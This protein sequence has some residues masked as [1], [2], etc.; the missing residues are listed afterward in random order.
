M[1]RSSPG[2][3]ATHEFGKN[4]Y[5]VK[6]FGKTGKQININRI[7]GDVYEVPKHDGTIRVDYTLYANY[8]DG[9]YAG[10]DAGGIHLNMPAVFMWIKGYDKIPIDIRF[11]IPEGKQWTIAT[12]LK[13]AGDATSFTAPGL[14]Y[15][16][17]CPTKI[18]D[19]VWK[20]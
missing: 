17:D 10:I 20:E 4:I 8:P 2:R 12:Q 15:F 14:Q 16:M 6:A 11:T 18:G 5:D 1:S 13:P 19:L 7:D 9:T 3:Y